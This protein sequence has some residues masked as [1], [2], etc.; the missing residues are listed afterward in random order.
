MRTAKNAR[1]MGRQVNPYIA[2][3][4]E[5]GDDDE[6]SEPENVYIRPKMQPY[7]LKNCYTILDKQEV[8]FDDDDEDAL[9]FAL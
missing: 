2:V 8:I 7:Q 1:L 9:I 6:L 4:P 3:P 5:N